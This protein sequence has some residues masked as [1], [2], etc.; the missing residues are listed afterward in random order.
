MT[1]SPFLID[2]FLNT[3]FHCHQ[4]KYK[5]S[6]PIRQVPLLIANEENLKG[7]GFLVNDPD[8]CEVE[9]VTWPA[10]G[11]RPID[12]GAGNEGIFPFLDEQSFRDR[13][14]KVHGRVS[15][16]LG[17]EFGCYLGVPL[18]TELPY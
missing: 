18:P 2:K 7:Y 14:G 9:I 4:V 15:C 12:A 1:V 10:Q 3:I 13:Q 11:W 8:H 17:Q 6:L 16:D 5:S